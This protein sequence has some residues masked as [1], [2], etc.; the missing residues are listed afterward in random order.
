MTV[1]QETSPVG[2]VFYDEAVADF[3]ED[4]VDSGRKPEEFGRIWCHTHPGDSAIPSCK[5]EETFSRVFGSCNWALMFILA[6]EGQTYCRLRFNVGS[7]GELEIPVEVKYREEFGPSN[8]E[9][10]EAEYQAN[11]RPELVRMLGLDETF[12]DPE[13]NWMKQSSDHRVSGKPGVKQFHSKKR[14]RK[15]GRKHEC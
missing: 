14:K 6:R 13:W 15:R 3:F 10:W 5:D 8:P 7:G 9:A 11:V 2:V 12:E 4:Q 1:R